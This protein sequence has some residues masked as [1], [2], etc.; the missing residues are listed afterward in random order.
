M[1]SYFS[2]NIHRQYLINASRWESFAVT[3]AELKG[4]GSLTTPL[5]F[6]QYLHSTTT[7]FLTS[8]PPYSPTEQWSHRLHSINCLHYLLWSLTCTRRPARAAPCGVLTIIRHFVVKRTHNLCTMWIAYT[9]GCAS[10]LITDPKIQCKCWPGSS[11]IL[12]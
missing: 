11:G 5:S 1:P 6:C 2:H 4:N 3:S 10:C 9:T 7:S 8:L 12:I